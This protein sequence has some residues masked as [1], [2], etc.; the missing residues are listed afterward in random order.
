ML[1][2]NS[3]RPLAAICS[4]CS[5][6]QLA[7][8]PGWTIGTRRGG[9]NRGSIRQPPGPFPHRVLSVDRVGGAHGAR[10]FH[11]PAALEAKDLSKV[12]DRIKP[13]SAPGVLRPPKQAQVHPSYQ[14][15]STIQ[16]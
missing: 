3:T 6:Q 7:R 1:E 11:L 2:R 12:L 13:G 9:R 10:S 5:Y 14:P 4:G 16:I 15:A 8:L